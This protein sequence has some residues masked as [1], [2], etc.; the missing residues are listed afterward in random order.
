M[1]PTVVGSGGQAH[2]RALTGQSLREARENHFAHRGAGFPRGAGAVGLEGDA[3]RLAQR[4]RHAGFVDEHIQTRARDAAGGECLGQVSLVDQT[5][6]SNVDQEAARPQRLE[7]GRVDDALGLVRGRTEDQRVGI[8][9]EID[10]VGTNR[11]ATSSM[12]RRSV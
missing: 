4:Q 9:R 10:Q 1:P 2:R 8:L 6:A 3:V 11:C 12:A 7:D 5:A